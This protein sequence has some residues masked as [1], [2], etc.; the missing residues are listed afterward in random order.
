M[1]PKF[2]IVTRT[3]LEES[4]RSDGAA[5]G[6]RI[7]NLGRSEISELLRKGVVE[8]VVADVGRHLSWIAANDCFHF[9][10]DEVKPHVLEGDSQAGLTSFS[11][12]YCYIASLWE[13]SG[14]ETPVILLE[15]H[16]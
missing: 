3:P 4:W 10:K 6:R 13:A 7:G 8:F 14:S 12:E 15:K 2:K 11:G 9:W 1:D 16:H 5:I